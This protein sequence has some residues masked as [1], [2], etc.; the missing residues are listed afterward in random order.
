M[1]SVKRPVSQEAAD[2]G[3][4][5]VGKH[6]L[7]ERCDDLVAFVSPR[8]GGSRQ[9]DQEEQ[10]GELSHF[11]SDGN[12]ALRGVKGFRIVSALAYQVGSWQN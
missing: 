4:D 5:V 10:G 2:L 8:K 3:Q 7:G 12:S 9:P 1:R 6:I 11:E